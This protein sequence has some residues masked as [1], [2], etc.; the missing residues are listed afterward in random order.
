MTQTLRVGLL[1]LAVLLAGQA[2]AEAHLW[3][4]LEALDGPGPARSRGNMATNIFC[5][6]STPGRGTGRLFQIPRDA[7]T[8]ATCLFVD[9]RRFRADE[10]DRFYQVDLS[11][12]E[13]GTS[14]RLHRSLEIG[15]GVG[16]LR[17]TSQNPGTD[18]EF[19]GARMTIT[20]PRLVFKPLLAAPGVR[21]PDWGFFHA[22]LRESIVVGELTQD[23]F[24]SK[25][26]NVFSRTHQRVRSMGFLIE[27]PSA[28]RL[29]K[30]GI[31][32]LGN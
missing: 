25:P 32:A 29:A 14:V 5:S 20:F 26:G 19:N 3:D 23:D 28:V 9:V 17:Y 1:S 10:D 8:V 18:Q 7:N 31:D 11:I 13:V 4:W 24:A 12:T 27:A 21:D 6:D 22:Y 16:V 15:A 30:R 2:R